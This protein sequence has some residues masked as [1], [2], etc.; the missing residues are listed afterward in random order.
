LPADLV[1]LSRSI[2]DIGLF[3]KGLL[4]LTM[5]PHLLNYTQTCV[6]RASMSSGTK[7][8]GFGPKFRPRFE[9]L[10]T[11]AVASAPTEAKLRG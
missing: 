6:S 10:P 2:R 4:Q 7:I 3:A 1:K 8:Y 5:A 11:V 9:V